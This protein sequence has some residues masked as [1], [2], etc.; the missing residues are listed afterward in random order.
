VQQS[1]F[2]N[3]EISIPYAGL[4][5]LNNYLPM[6]FEKL[7]LIKDNRFLSAAKQSAAVSYLQYLA[8]GSI[9]KD[10]RGT[11]LNKLLCGMDINESVQDYF[12]I[13]AV[14]EQ[15]L[16]SLIIAVI[17]Y[18][19]AIGDVSVNGF[20]GNWLVR[21]GTLSAEEDKWELT[22][23]RRAYD[24]L[25]NQSPFSFSIIKHPWMEKPLHVSWSF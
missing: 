13:T 14:D 12:D 1:N 6:L 17:G 5:L 16:N 11:Q 21:K 7:E 18:W 2:M 25:I 3:K 8:A 24:I 15:L 23:E 4:V 20:R 9:N 10:G 22:V 19:P